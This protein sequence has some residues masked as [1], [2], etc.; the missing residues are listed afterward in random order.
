MTHFEIHYV[1][2]GLGAKC[3]ELLAAQVLLGKLIGERHQLQVHTR[4]VIVVA[5]LFGEVS[6]CSGCKVS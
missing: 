3:G 5:R 6:D 2:D 4:Q 1:L